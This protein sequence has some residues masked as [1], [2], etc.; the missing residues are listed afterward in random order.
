MPANIN[1]LRLD[2]IG[3][4]KSHLTIKNDKALIH[5]AIEESKAFFV[6]VLKLLPGESKKPPVFERLLLPDYISNDILQYLIEWLTCSI[7]FI[8]FSG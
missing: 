1:N 4:P 5:I 6:C 3:I 2:N 7:I 8:N